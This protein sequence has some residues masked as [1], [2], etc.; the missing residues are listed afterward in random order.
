[1]EFLGPVAVAGTYYVQAL[2][3]NRGTLLAGLG[4]GALT[5]AI[6]VV[7]NLRDHSTDRVA[8]KRTL[9]VRLGPT[10]TKAEFGLLI[11][12]ALVAPVVGVWRVQKNRA[13][14]AT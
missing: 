8:G 5:T 13:A 10:L 6:L 7:N 9:A 3:W 12:V 2:N 4:V 14:L 11:L 1:M